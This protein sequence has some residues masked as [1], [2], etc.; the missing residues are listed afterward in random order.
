[1]NS[2]YSNI[3]G[4]CGVISNGKQWPTFKA[5]SS[6]YDLRTQCLA[7][8]FNA[9][10]T[11]R[12]CESEWFTMRHAKIMN[13][14]HS[15]GRIP[16]PTMNNVYT[17]PYDP[18]NRNFCE[19]SI[20]NTKIST[21][22]SEENLLHTNDSIC[23]DAS[24]SIIAPMNSSNFT[25]IPSLCDW[26]NSA[27]DSSLESSKLP[28]LANSHEANEQPSVADTYMNRNNV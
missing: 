19:A 1:M 8:P 18:T 28:S 26:K 14:Y 5:D 2:L 27:Y 17:V 9:M 23:S 11:N 3:E 7:S 25:D 16:P 13:P 6:A 24:K 12:I 15:L 20:T 21:K 4:D 22:F 10:Q